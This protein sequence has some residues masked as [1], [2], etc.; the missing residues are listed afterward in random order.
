M[1]GVVAP[2]PPVAQASGVVSVLAISRLGGVVGGSTTVVI[3]TLDFSM[4]S[5][6][7]YLALRSAG[8]L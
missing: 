3:W 6:S 1:S 7:G 8:G 2:T 5:N 4:A